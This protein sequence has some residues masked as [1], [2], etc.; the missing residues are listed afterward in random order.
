VLSTTLHLGDNCE[1]CG[2]TARIHLQ[3]P[4]GVR[5]EVVSQ[6]RSDW[7]YCGGFVDSSGEVLQR[8]VLFERVSSS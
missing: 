3:N 7:I 8:H 6:S 1:N 2:A 4:F 5:I